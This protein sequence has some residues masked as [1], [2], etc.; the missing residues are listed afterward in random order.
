[1]EAQKTV[2]SQGDTEQ[3]K[4]NKHWRYHNIQLQTKLQSHSNK[5]SI[6][7]AQKQT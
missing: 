3:T 1:M 5:N 6:I 2:N 4:Q 7:F